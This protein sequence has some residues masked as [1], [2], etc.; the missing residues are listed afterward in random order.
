MVASLNPSATVR[1]F[2]A[3]S[4]GRLMLAWL[5]VDIDVGYS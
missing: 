4:A 2:L 1:G 3:M 5:P